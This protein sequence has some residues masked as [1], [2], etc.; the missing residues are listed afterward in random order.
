MKYNFFYYF[1]F[2]Q[3]IYNRLPYIYIYIYIDRERER[4][5]ERERG[6]ISKYKICTFVKSFPS[7]ITKRTIT[8]RSCFRN[9]SSG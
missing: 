9:R 2:T 4:E 7:K 5:R 8:R 6:N 3:L 1:L